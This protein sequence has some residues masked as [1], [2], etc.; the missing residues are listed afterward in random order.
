MHPLW[1]LAGASR[2]DLFRPPLQV[3]A[4]NPTSKRS[5]AGSSEA[6]VTERSVR[7][8]LSGIKVRTLAIL[9]RNS[10]RPGPIGIL[11]LVVLAGIVAVLPI[12]AGAA[13]PA[14]V[15]GCAAG[16]AKLRQMQATVGA[17]S[18]QLP[19]DAAIV[20]DSHSFVL[21]GTTATR[22][23]PDKDAKLDTLMH[24][25]A[26]GAALCAIKMPGGVSWLVLRGGDGLLRYVP[27]VGTQSVEAHEADM[28]RMRKIWGA[29]PGLS[30]EG[31][32]TVRGGR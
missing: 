24:A 1:F 11:R 4:R 30:G 21:L 3:Y 27:Q 25:G 31:A 23:W 14:T 6:R 19:A 18:P 28:V 29:A 32:R 17:G 15:R 20:E 22:Y 2:D 9:F 8:R 12:A 16:P 13:E 7:S 26:R 5:P 10:L